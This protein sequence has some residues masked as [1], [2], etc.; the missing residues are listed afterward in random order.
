MKK[1]NKLD[2]FHYHEMTDRLFMICQILGEFIED[3]PVYEQ[4]RDLKRLVDSAGGK[5]ADAYQLSGR[6]GYDFSKK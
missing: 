1:E 2:N 5:L 6:L 3:H 4:H